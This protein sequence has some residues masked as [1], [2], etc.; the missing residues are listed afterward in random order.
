MCENN[1]MHLNTLYEMM[2][3]YKKKYSSYDQCKEDVISTTMKEYNKNKLKTRYGYPVT[4]KSQAIAIALNQTHNK[5]K[6]NKGEKE[7]L[8][9]KVNRDFNDKNKELILSNLVEL[10]DVLHLMI[11]E[12]KHKQVEELKTLLWDKIIETYRS[13]KSLESN[14]WD[15]IKKIHEL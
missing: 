4:E 1:L 3:G 15:E 8:I 7:H 9:D 11:K 14:M 10:Y 13:N 2:G 6:Y 12:R 5:C